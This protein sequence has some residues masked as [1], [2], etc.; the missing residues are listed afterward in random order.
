MKMAQAMEATML[1]NHWIGGA[2]VDT[3]SGRTSPVWNPGTGEQVG[4][5][6]LAS[7]KDVDH[8]VAVAKE[9]FVGWRSSA[10]GRRAEIMFKLRNLI[11]Q[12]RERLATIIATENGKTLADAR[13]E[14]AR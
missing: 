13:G 14:V 9:A 3:E 2:A 6:N 7:V 11:D 1:I 12:N 4:S 8:A 5:V 10:L